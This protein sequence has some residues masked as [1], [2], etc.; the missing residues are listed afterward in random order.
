VKLFDKV[1][2]ACNEPA[3]IKV[4]LKSTLSKF[5]EVIKLDPVFE[6]KFHQSLIKNEITE[7]LITCL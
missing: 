5:E 3:T 4:L 6:F 2:E 7:Y 1:I